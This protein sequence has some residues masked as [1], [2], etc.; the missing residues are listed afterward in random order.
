MRG[1]G[2]ILTVL[3]VLGAGLLGAAFALA[4]GPGMAG[5]LVFKFGP[6]LAASNWHYVSFPRRH[7][8]EF[9]AHGDE[10]IVVQA[11]AGVGLLWH[12]VPPWG[13]DASNARWRWRVME[14][15]GPTDLS[16]KGGDDRALAIYFA[17]ADDEEDISEQTDLV[18][19]LRQE[20]G[21]VLV[22]AWGGIDRR[23]S[24]LP[25]P[26]FGGRGATVVKRAAN[27]RQGVWFTETAALSDDFRSAFG[28]APGKL[29][30]V[31]VSSDS[32]DTGDV[33]L[34]AVADFCI[35]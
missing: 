20:R 25:L 2:A 30:A 1:I 26:Y 19:L 12:S 18:D 21:Y 17:F 29:V 8:A 33:N 11:K 14:G 13:S 23:G 35:N 6:D 34:A 31:A 15:V 10:T 22:Y 24:V 9:Q 27:A 32:D 16:K 3:T 28:R 4:K 7:G 5:G